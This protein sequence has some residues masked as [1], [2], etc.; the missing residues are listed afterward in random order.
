MEKEKTETEKET[1]QEKY[2]PPKRKRLPDKPSPFRNFDYKFK[3]GKRFTEMTDEEKKEYF[4]AAAFNFRKTREKAIGLRFHTNKKD[5]MFI[6]FFLQ[7]MPV[8]KEKFIRYALL[9]H[10]KNNFPEF[11]S[12]FPKFKYQKDY[13]PVYY[14]RLVTYD[15][16]TNTSSAWAK[17]LGYN[18]RTLNS[19]LFNYKMPVERAFLAPV[20]STKK[21]EPDRVVIT[22]E[23]LDELVRKIKNKEIKF[24]NSKPK[25]ARNK[26][27][28]DTSYAY[29]PYT[30]EEFTQLDIERM[31]KGL[32]D[33]YLG[34]NGVEFN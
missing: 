4:H 27:R 1:N 12:Y 9:E 32:L 21:G 8:C 6:Y 31:N 2:T 25:Y 29:H 14:A 26:K 3:F 11:F 23:E 34:E 28:L 22:K 5:E 7:T 33:N 19:R 15:G 16:I 13:T 10:I 30:N 24:K 20:R 18:L 17:M